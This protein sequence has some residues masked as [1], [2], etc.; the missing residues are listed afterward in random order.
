MN[1]YTI[2]NI[3]PSPLALCRPSTKP[4]PPPSRQ[5][6]PRVIDRVG[7]INDDDNQ[8]PNQPHAIHRIMII[9]IKRR[10]NSVNRMAKETHLFRESE[11]MFCSMS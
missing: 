5:G 7:G 1:D 3:P 9:G 8:Q 10:H 2:L 4:P 11:Q 6:R